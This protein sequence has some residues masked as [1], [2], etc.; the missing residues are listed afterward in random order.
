MSEFHEKFEKFR[1][2]FSKERGLIMAINSVN[3]KSNSDLKKLYLEYLNS[4]CLSNR[5]HYAAFSTEDFSIN[6]LQFIL[7]GI[8]P[9]SIAQSQKI[10]AKPNHKDKYAY[11]I[12]WLTNNTEIF[13]QI[14]YFYLVSSETSLSDKEFFIFNTFPA[15]FSSFTTFEDQE[16]AV[17][18]LQNLFELH[19]ELHGQN[20]SYQHKF[21]SDLCLSFFITTNPGHFFGVVLKPLLREFISKA[22]HSMLMYKKKNGKLVR[23][24]YY[25]VCIA[26][27]QKLLT[28]MISCITLLPDSARYFLTKISRSCGDQKCMEAFLFDST[29]CEYLKNNLLNDEYIVLSDVCEVIKT[30][31]PQ[32]FMPSKIYNEIKELCEISSIGDLSMF[33]NSLKLEEIVKT[34]DY[35]SMAVSMCE[36]AFLYSPKDLQLIYNMTSIF[37]KEI[38]KDEAIQQLNDAI[39]AVASLL[40]SDD[41]KVILIKLWGGSN[42]REKLELK[43]T[44]TYDDIIDGLSMIDG[45]NM[46]YK[47]GQ[48]LAD[49]AILYSGCFMDSMQK[50]RISTT[51]ETITIDTLDNAL[52]SV[53]ENEQKINHLSQ[54][55]FSAIYF[56]TTDKKIHDEQSLREMNRLVLLK[57]LPLMK[58]LYPKEFD[59][60]LNDIFQAKDNLKLVFAALDG[61]IK[62]MG[63]PPPHE[64][65]ISRALFGEYFDTLEKVLMFQN[66]SVTKTTETI[67]QNY[68]KQNGSIINSLSNTHLNLLKQAKDLFSLVNQNNPPTRNLGLVIDGM[69]LLKNF[70]TDIISLS[71]AQTENRALIGFNTFIRSYI[72]DSKI[73]VV[74][75]DNDELNL[76]KLFNTSVLK[77]RP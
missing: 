37:V 15:I 76:I 45:N 26:F 59:F 23:A 24:M 30:I 69:R 2:D 27:A 25:D 43:P 38:E 9:L 67:L 74:M 57:F 11:L 68:N 5:L 70:N 75:F 44:K 71:I 22:K 53:V 50:L 46:N 13:S 58:S 10:F 41:D 39:N 40:L 56:I 60:S 36:K 7:K 48:Q 14:V 21:L 42:Q 12:Y 32:S 17:N 47:T 19:F 63:F 64:L 31:F 8:T 49:S 33:F 65:M 62:P 55:L 34:D 1:E 77:I 20:F 3:S 28:R 54:L 29:I 6:S 16:N 73:Q 18:F 52:N 51:V 35:I 61:I 66:T 4:L 72:S